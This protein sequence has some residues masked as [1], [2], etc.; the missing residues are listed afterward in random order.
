MDS[1]R[2]RSRKRPGR[3]RWIRTGKRRL[4]AFLIAAVFTSVVA[5]VPFLG[6]G[7]E[8]GMTDAFAYD[9]KD[10][11]WATASNIKYKEGN[12]QD[13][14]IYVI[15]EDNDVCPGNISAMTLYLKNNTG[16]EISG[17]ELTFSSRY[18][19]QENGGFMDYAAAENGEDPSALTEITLEP[20]ELREIFFEFYTEEEAGPAKA[21]VTF[22]FRGEAG[23]KEIRSSQRFH[24][25]IGL[26]NV[27]LE[28]RDGDVVE[29]GVPLEME[30]WMSEPDWQDWTEETKASEVWTDPEATGSDLVKATDSE[31]RGDPKATDSELSWK[32]E[33]DLE[34]I[35]EFRD[36]A[37]EIPEARV[38]YELEIFGADYKGF[39]PRK[40]KETEDLGWVSCIYRLA[41]DVKPGIYY[42]KVKA[43]GSWNRRSFTAEQGFLFEVTGEGIITLK[44]GIHGTEVEISGSPSSFPEADELELRLEPLT[45]EGENLLRKNG[46]E[47]EQIYTGVSLKLLADGEESSLTGPVTVKLT[48]SAME[49]IAAGLTTDLEG[50]VEE[51]EAAAAETAEADLVEPEESGGESREATPA[52]IPEPV[53]RQGPG[54]VWA[55][56]TGEEV[57][58]LNRIDRDGTL[59][60]RQPSEE[61]TEDFLVAAGGQ[62]GISLLALDLNE[63]WAEA[64][65]CAV[66]GRGWIQTETDELPGAYAAV[67]GECLTDGWTG[68]YEDEE[69]VVSVTIPGIH[70]MSEDAEVFVDKIASESETGGKEEYEALWDGAQRSLSQGVISADFYEIQIRDKGTGDVWSLSDLGD[71]TVSANVKV[72]L[73]KGL[74]HMDMEGTLEVLHFDGGESPPKVLNAVTGGAQESREQNVLTASFQTGKL[75]LFGFVW[76]DPVEGVETGGPGTAGF[77]GGGIL[78]MAWAVWL[79]KRRTADRA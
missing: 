41:E 43:S 13:V 65:E 24:Y 61:E 32:E 22:H 15:S 12:Q 45:E 10:S 52:E 71:S 4:C 3:R 51:Q 19:E 64:V 58:S 25:G 21:S 14:D 23:E 78:L 75:G 30:I 38:Q 40:A 60:V 74:P 37:M 36:R 69:I 54:A 7:T 48:D 27:N 35:R 2:G 67:R 16:Q 63:E 39:K 28:L 8:L 76:A 66:T 11:L 17:G 57:T 20:G 77:A 42:G 55:Y 47:A 9:G 59:I 33:E 70:T 1:M 29:T 31:L 5:D 34:T 18:I 49:E 26:P 46:L 62:A 53:I 44:D 50:P 79:W 72:H 68:I 73:K 56:M 6:M